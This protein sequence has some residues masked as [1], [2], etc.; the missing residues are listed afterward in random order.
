MAESDVHTDAI[1]QQEP[2]DKDTEPIHKPASEGICVVVIGATGVTGRYVVAELL[3]CPE[4]ASVRVVS[5]RKYEIPR[6]YANSVIVSNAAQEGKLVEHIVDLEKVSEEELR[7]MF[8][9]VHTFFNC[10]GST[11]SKAGSKERFVQIDMNIPVRFAHIAREKGVRHTSLLTSSGANDKSFMFY[12]RVKG[13]IETAYRDLGFP[14]LSIFRPGLL[15]RKE[16]MKMSEKFI[17]IFQSTLQTDDLA[18]GMVQDCL[19]MIRHS[20]V[21]LNPLYTSLQ[22]KALNTERLKE[23]RALNNPSV[24]NPEYN[25][26][27]SGTVPPVVMDFSHER[28]ESA[29]INAT[30]ESAGVT[31]DDTN[32]SMKTVDNSIPAVSNEVTVAAD[33]VSTQDGELENKQIQPVET[34]SSAQQDLRPDIVEGEITTIGGPVTEKATKPTLATTEPMTEPNSHTTELTEPITEPP[35]PI[36]EPTEPIT[37]PTEPITEPTE[38]I[39][40]SVE[41]ISEPTEPI[42]EPTEP[43]TEPIEPITESVEPITEPTEPIADTSEPIIEPTPPAP[44]TTE[45]GTDACTDTEPNSDTSKE[46]ATDYPSDQ[47]DSIQNDP[48]IT[49]TPNSPDS[50]KDVEETALS[51]SSDKIHPENVTLPDSDMSNDS[52]CS[53]G[54][55]DLTS[56]STKPDTPNSSFQTANSSDVSDPITPKASDY[57]P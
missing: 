36:S 38:P 22:I 34:E 42:T 53:A 28:N 33:N 25:E 49:P 55:T 43:I 23:L 17:S 7:H 16:Q 30:K 56:P 8:E 4:I 45:P 32:S 39:T 35:E 3:L 31:A 2:V 24:E 44:E 27:D 6:E 57:N 48:D 52:N 19:N 50:S 13:L 37:E 15:G 20:D 54:D 51:P 1:A 10:F 11:R 26:D 12:F 29:D 18:R 47:N 14:A 9:G 5:R 41:P 21:L 40:E 46:N